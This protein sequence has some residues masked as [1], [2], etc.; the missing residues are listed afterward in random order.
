MFKQRTLTK[1]INQASK[2]FP[3]ILLTGPRQV[4]KTRLFEE[5]KTRKRNYVTLDDP[6]KR[7]LAKKDPAL[8][9][10]LHKPP[11]TIDEVQ[12]AP[13]LFSY[14]KIAVDSE[15][16][17]GMF[18]LTGSQKFHL[19]RGITETLAG[20]VAI[21]DMLGLS[22]AEMDG[23]AA[24]V[25]PFIPSQ[26]WLAG[27]RKNI[28][29]KKQ[30]KEIYKNIWLGSYPKLLTSKNISR[31]LFYQ[32]YIETYMQ[33][34]VRDLTKVGDELSFMKFLRVAAART[35]QL[36]NY[37]DMANDADIDPKTAKSWLSILET[38]GL[39]YL[40]Y[41]YYRN[42]TKRL[43]KTP[44][45]YFLDTGL[46]AFL[47]Q[48]PSSEL[49]ESGAMS[50]AIFETYIFSE[51]LKTYWHNGKNPYFYYYRD[52]D[53]KEIDLLIEQ[54]DTIY[55]IEFKKTASPSLNASKNFPILA[56]L[57]RKIGHG[58]VICLCEED[59]PLSR[60]VDAIPVGYL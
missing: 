10:Q 31:D 13:E 44:K 4:G 57:D 8:F 52:H 26:K 12:Y 27:T 32:S 37:H 11:I 40:L 3:I 48:W 21:L 15:R 46:C 50:G 19:M 30:V 35:G 7:G 54:G 58:A 38:S 47:T 53:Q 55:P 18:W 45:L 59:I 34:D 42:V 29:R 49:L 36:L 41:P 14:I 17:S 60:E 28:L 5:C 43:V 51:I 56:K 22:Q 25:L 16:K 2:S 20:R 33:R 9:L 24:S 39:I 23:R 6:E 1:T